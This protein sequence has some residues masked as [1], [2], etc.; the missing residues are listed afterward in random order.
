MEHNTIIIKG[1]SYSDIKKALQQWMNLYEK[2]LVSDI[3]LE[4]YKNGRG[5]HIIK[6][7]K[8]IDNERFYYLVNYLYYP[9]GINYT[10][11]IEGFTTAANPE[12]IR[13]KNLLIYIPD[14]DKEGDNVFAVTED[15]NTFKIDFGGKVKP[16][17]GIRQ[18]RVPEIG[19][20]S[21]PEIIRVNKIKAIT[22]S[23]TE[24]SDNYRKSFRI[25]SVILLCVIILSL[26]ML[27]KSEAFFFKTTFI[28][29]IAIWAW[30]FGDYEMLRV[31]KY[32][33]FSFCL[34]IA[35]L[36]YGLLIQQYETTE[37]KLSQ[38]GSLLPLTVLIIQK[39]LRFTFK[40]IFK[41]EPVVERNDTTLW[42]MIYAIILFLA[43]VSIPFIIED[44]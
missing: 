40:Q 12:M 23:K 4:L 6:A 38:L 20:L 5:H 15:N 7:D 28:I 29:A 17:A 41:R 11:N 22:K 9:E 32:Y 1:G 42:D 24:A 21:N 16:A 34:A 27:L 30:F 43:S 3:T 36:G 26:L 31:E 13:N 2:D 39:P 25:I 33:W 18:Y 10:I 19:E 35:F 37:V 8:R 44:K 14:T